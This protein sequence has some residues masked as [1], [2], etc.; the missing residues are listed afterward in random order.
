MVHK[1]Q[2]LFQAS[3]FI[4]TGVLLEHTYVMPLMRMKN[5]KNNQLP[6]KSLLDILKILYLRARMVQN[7]F[8]NS[9]IK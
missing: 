9:S 1:M 4:N 2:N 3:R 8:F 7:Y 6:F 5:H